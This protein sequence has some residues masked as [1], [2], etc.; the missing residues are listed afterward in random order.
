MPEKDNHRPAGSVLLVEDSVE[1]REILAEI[2]AQEHFA[3]VSAGDGLRAWELIKSRSF[4][5]VISDLGLPG[6]DGGELLRKMRENSISTPVLLTCGVKAKKITERG[7][8]HH[9]SLIYKPFEINEIKT[10]IYDLLKL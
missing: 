2:L 7:V 8:F 9:Y 6:I 1:V 10:A 4:D 3:V 5:L